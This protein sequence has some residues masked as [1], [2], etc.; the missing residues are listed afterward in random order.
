MIRP[1]PL[2]SACLFWP[3]LAPAPAAAL[4]VEIQGTRLEASSIGAS[5]IEIA[6]DYAGVRVEASEKGKAARICYNSSSKVNSIAILNSTF[7]AL[8]PAKKELSIKFEHEFPPG[9]NGKVMVRAKL[10]GFFSAANGVGVPT[11]DKLTLTPY[12][13]QSYHDDAIAEPFNLDVGE[14]MDSAL[15]DYA[16]KKR[17]LISGPRTLKGGLKIV[18]S[19]AGHKLTLVDKSGLTIDT[20]STMADK[21]ETMSPEGL[22]G[23]EGAVAPDGAPATPAAMPEG[24]GIAPELPSGPITL[25]PSGIEGIPGQ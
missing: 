24:G 6:G 9:L 4:V 16:A 13:S 21:L 8:A 11:G 17:Y 19:T 3:L 15:F 2:L 12:F 22:P 25:P 23:E 5:C 1:H 14:D 18:F 20:G 7:T 10:Q